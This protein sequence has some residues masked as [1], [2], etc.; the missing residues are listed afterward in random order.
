MK[1]IFYFYKRLE[2]LSGKILYI[3]L[4]GIVIVSFLQGMEIFMLIPLISV[5]GVMNMDFGSSNFWPMFKFVEQFPQSVGLPLVLGI[6]LFLVLC[7]N[8]LQRTINRQNSKI[9]QGFILHLRLEVYRAVLQANWGFFIKKRKSDII[10]SL[11]TELGRVTG[12]MAVFLRLHTNLIFTLIQVGLALWL[13]VKLTVFVLICGFGIALLNRRF[14]KKAKVLGKLTSKLS[15]SYLAAITDQLNGIKEIKSNTLEESRLTWFENL[16]RKME[17]E[18]N[19]YVKLRTNSEFSSKISSAVLIAFCILL[20]VKALHAQP[21]Q[22]ILI[23][24]IFSRLWPRFAGIQ[25]DVEHIASSIPALKAVAE[26]EKECKEAQELTVIETSSNTIKPVRIE[27]G[28]ECRNLYFRY[29]QKESMYALQDVSL[30]IPAKGMTAIVGRS[31]AGKSTL[32]DILMGL[33]QPEK[34]QLLIDGKPF[35]S[36]KLLS[37][38]SSVSY[39]PQDPFLFN[40]TI[41]E[42]LLLVKPDATEQELWQALDIS[43][44]TEFVRLLPQ[45]LDTIIGDRGVRLSGGERQRLVLARALLRKPC[46]LVLDEATSSLDSENETK[47]QEVLDRIKGEMTIIVIAHRLSTIRNADQVIVIDKGKVIQKGGFSQL[48]QEKRGLFSKLL[49]HQVESVFNTEGH[50]QALV[51]ERV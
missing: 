45:G 46:I 6:F 4:L 22:L 16:T 5:S 1:H 33:I 44:S 24:L 26:L 42:N 49:G 23:I 3:N 47:I 19:E 18:Q 15:Q 31:G 12:G 2:A 13:S 9:H 7:Q 37:L 41:R 50:A 28:L 30:E 21:Q 34:G 8:L 48:A 36:D 43:V 10:N 40:A 51:T 11:T 39:V 29:N 20:S 25:A 38:R 17:E 35:S 27:Q 14:V 32:V